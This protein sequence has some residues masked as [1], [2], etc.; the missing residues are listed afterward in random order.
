MIAT[1]GLPSHILTKNN[2]SLA[3]SL[4]RGYAQ[5]EKDAYVTCADKRCN[6]NNPETSLRA[7][8]SNLFAKIADA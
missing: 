8:I 4:Q 2:F 7:P 3:L 6:T 1:K 5:P